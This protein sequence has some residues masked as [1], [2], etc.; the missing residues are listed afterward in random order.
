MQPEAG[1]Y[2]W[3]AIEAARLALQF[4]QGKTFQDYQTDALLRSGVERQLLIVGEALSRLRLLDRAVADRIPDLPRA[5]GLRNVLAHA[6]A[7]VDDAVICGLLS[8]PL[9]RLI[10]DMQA[11]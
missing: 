8:G 6:Y 4:I 5:V 3:D 10:E 9:G 11:V 1:K 7:D 2:L